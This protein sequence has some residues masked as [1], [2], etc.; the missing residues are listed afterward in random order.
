SISRSVWRAVRAHVIFYRHRKVARFWRTIINSYFEKTIEIRPVIPLKEL[1]DEKVIWQYWAQGL[2]EEHLPEL[3]KICFDTVDKYKGEYML[4]R[5]TD[6][7]VH[8]YL[9][10]PDFVA[11][12]R[13]NKEYR[14]VFFSDLLRVALLKQYGGVWL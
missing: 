8:S 6:E 2:S 12:K 13:A 9:K 3:V 1:K 14:P 4:I 7:T 11:K 5:L 10:F